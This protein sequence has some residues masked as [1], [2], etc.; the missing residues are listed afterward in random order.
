MAGGNE[1]RAAAEPSLQRYPG[2]HH[3]K[4]YRPGPVIGRDS[5]AEN[6]DE[7]NKSNGRE[8]ENPV[9]EPEPDTAEN[10]CQDEKQHDDERPAIPVTGHAKAATSL[11]S[12]S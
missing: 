8:N 12:E 2:E 1:V 10:C 7:K 5:D 9:A 3:P 6:G 4:E 11:A